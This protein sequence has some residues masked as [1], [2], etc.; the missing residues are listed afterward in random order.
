M[1]SY[2][3]YLHPLFFSLLKQPIFSGHSQELREGDGPE[4]EQAQ[5]QQEQHAQGGPAHEQ[6]QPSKHSKVR[7]FYHIQ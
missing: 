6:T 4:D 7:P 5:I 3:F 1:I 2:L